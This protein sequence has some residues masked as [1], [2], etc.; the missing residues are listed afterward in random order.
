MLT[1]FDLLR[2]FATL[3]GGTVI[4]IYGFAKLGV[5]G[6]LIGVPVGLIL[7]GIT[8]RLLFIVALRLMC[9]EFDGLTDAE[10]VS[11]LHEADC[12]TPNL[13]LL[14]LRRRG[15]D[16]SKELPHVHSLLTSPQLDRRT[17]G[18]AALTSAFPD[19]VDIIKGYDPTAGTDDCQKYCKPLLDATE[20]KVAAEP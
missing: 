2:F 18:W 10:M 4:G 17:A 5:V 20:P 3:G 9:R 16:I 11:R 15:Y 12:L 19:L 8:G 7:G 13:H 6:I 14:E 1:L